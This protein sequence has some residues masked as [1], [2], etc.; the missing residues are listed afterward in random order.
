MRNLYDFC[1]YKKIPIN[2]F[3]LAYYEFGEGNPVIVLHGNNQDSKSLSKLIKQLSCSN[4][5]LAI[6]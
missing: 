2:D 4:K 6:D 1:N 3:N 5:V